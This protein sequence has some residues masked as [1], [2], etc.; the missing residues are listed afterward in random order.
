MMRIDV[1]HVA[2]G[3]VTIA[4]VDTAGNMG[5]AMPKLMRVADLK[6]PSPPKN[7]KADAQ[8]DGTILLTWEMDDTLDLHYYDVLFANAP[9]HEFTL[10]NKRT[11]LLLRLAAGTRRRRVQLCHRRACH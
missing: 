11:L 9:D 2:T 4:A 8:L 3:M 6:P 1:T 10:A 5:Y 7:L